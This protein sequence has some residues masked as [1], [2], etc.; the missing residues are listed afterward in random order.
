MLE[1]L[2]KHPGSNRLR[3]SFI[4]CWAC[5][6]LLLMLP[7]LKGCYLSHLADC[8]S[9]P[10]WL[11][12]LAFTLCATA[13]RPLIYDSRVNGLEQDLCLVTGLAH[14]PLH[15]HCSRLLLTTASFPTGTEAASWRKGQLTS[16]HD[17]QTLFPFVSYTALAFLLTHLTLCSSAPTPSIRT[18]L[19]GRQG[20]L[21]V[22]PS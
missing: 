8:V 15:P 1:E 2:R 4:M 3:R 13:Q 19:Q 18:R 14:P 20:A 17:H 10:S 9:E 22:E 21:Y 12:C 6:M 7:V 11:L 16:R 5:L